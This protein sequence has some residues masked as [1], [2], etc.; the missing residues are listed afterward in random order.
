MTLQQIQG[1]KK[2][3]I[4]Q[5]A[6]LWF[7]IPP[8]KYGGIERI[9]S[10]LTEELVKRGH[11]VT[12]FASGDSK[13]KAKLFSVCP[14]SLIRAGYNWQDPFWNLENL[15]E[16]LKR[17]DDFDILHSHLDLWA[18]PFQELTKRP[19][20][21]T[22]HNQLYKASITRES[23]RKPTR[24]EIFE[25]HKKNTL[26]IFISESERKLSAVKF[27][28]SFV[29]Y[30]GIDVSQFKFNPKPKDHFIWIARIDPFKGIENAIRAAEILNVKLLLAGRLD[31]ARKEYFETKIQPHLSR[32]I[33]Y[34]G[35]LSSEEISD[36][37]GSAL[38][39]LYPIEWE[40]P[41]G[42]IMVEAMA[43]GTPVIAYRRGSVP[44]VIEDGKT[45]FVVENIEEMVKA[46]K[47]I[48]TISRKSCRQRVEKYFTGKKMVDEYEKLYFKIV[49][50][51]L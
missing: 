14:R 45:G 13:T 51:N 12:L 9:V 8:K 17:A 25:K 39:C 18:L 35:E 16:A 7:S 36:F 15:S 27:P 44:E 10:Y 26:A 1:K 31:P 42:L 49:S 47:K 32:K 29:I 33:R 28:K 30:N 22:F 11:D 40:E 4:A 50:K 19:V 24:L 46:M 38:A 41:F 37:Y 34:L 5:I 23:E 3:R 2:L 20:L 6:P 48:D 43:C 21:H